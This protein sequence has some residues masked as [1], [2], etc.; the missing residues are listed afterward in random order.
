MTR[1]LLF[2][3][4]MTLVHTNGAGRLA[5]DATLL[6]R[7]GVAQPT[8]GIRFDGRTDRAIFLD[9]LAKLEASTDAEYDALVEGY[10]SRLPLALKERGGTVLPGVTDLLDALEPAGAA[11]GLA[12]GNMR[13]GAAAKLGH[14]GLWERFAAGGFGDE[15]VVRAN[16][17][18]RG[19][20]DLAR[21]A[22]VIPR[23]VDCIVLGDTPL[24]VEAARAA[25]ARAMAIATGAY[26]EGALRD[27]GADW[28]FTDLSDTAAVLEV[29]LS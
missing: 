4:D 27:S 20:E 26:D 3:I 22:G 13:A 7:F 10:L 5:M 8:A 17:V 14:Y 11:I 29:L 23:E 2:D 12:T 19:I 15:E 9:A 28:V 18:R 1:L 16:V 21:I 24:D 6:E 25:G